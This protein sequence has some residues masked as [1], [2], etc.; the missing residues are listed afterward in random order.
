MTA[1]LTTSEL[2]P[3]GERARAADAVTPVVRPGRGVHIP[4]LDGLRG[5]AILLVV[6]GLAWLISYSLYIWH[7]PLIQ[8]FRTF[9]EP[10]V[11]HWPLPVVYG[12]YWVWVL[13]VVFPLSL[14][15]YLLIEK[16]WMQRAERLQGGRDKQAE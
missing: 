7:V 3:D 4:A 5:V 2:M 8:L 1:A 14:A 9:V 12:L 16:P 10:Y 11:H 6:T 13:L 15:S